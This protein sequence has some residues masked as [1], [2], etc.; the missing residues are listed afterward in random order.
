MCRNEN[1]VQLHLSG[2]SGTSSGYAENPD[3][4]IFLWK[5]ATMAVWSS[6]V[7]LY[8]MHLR[9]KLLIMPHLKLQNPQQCTALDLIT[10]NFKASYFCR[11]LRKIT[12]GPSQYG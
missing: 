6:A 10:G 9:P 3:N 2:L 8:S 4:W 5:Q 7:T 1:T 12:E 11:I